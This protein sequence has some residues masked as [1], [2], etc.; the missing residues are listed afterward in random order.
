MVCG[1]L[2]YASITAEGNNGFQLGQDSQAGNL[3]SP[4]NQGDGIQLERRSL[5]NSLQEAIRDDRILNKDLVF[6]G[7]EAEEYAELFAADSNLY[8]LT[9]EIKG[10][11]NGLNVRVFAKIEGSISLD[12]DYEIDGSEEFIFLLVNDTKSNRETVIRVDEKSTDAI[13]A[14][15]AG[16]VGGVGKTETSGGGGASGGSGTSGGGAADTGTAEAGTDAAEE[17]TAESGA[18]DQDSSAES[19]DPAE[20]EDASDGHS[21][22][23]ADDTDKTGSDN[24][25]ENT[26]SADNGNEADKDASQTEIDDSDVPG[27]ETPDSP[28]DDNDASDQD[29]ADSGQ[30]DSD[31]SGDTDDGA[32]DNS[33]N[34]DSIES[35]A[36]ISRH[37][38]YRV[39]AVASSSDSEGK[40]TSS[41]A[42]PEKWIDGMIYQTVLLKGD[43]VTAFV[44]TAEDLGLDDEF[45]ETATGSNAAYFYEVDLDNANIQV[46]ADEGVL[47]ENAELRA[48]ELAEDGDDTDK[49]QEAKDALDEEG[50]EYDGMLAYDISFWDVEG[51][52]I[53][54][55]GDVRV[56][57][58]MN[59]DVLPEEVDPQSL[60]VQHHAETDRGI[61]VEP[62]ADA[63]DVTAGIVEVSDSEAVVEFT[64]DSFS[65]FTIT[66]TNNNETSTYFEVTVAYVDEGGVPI[67]VPSVDMP[68]PVIWDTENN[69]VE[70]TYDVS[71]NSEYNVSI[72]GYEYV[73]AKYGTRDIASFKFSKGRYNFSSRTLTFYNSSGTSVGTANTQ[74]VTVNL[75]YKA[76]NVVEDTIA[77]NGLLTLNYEETLG[78]T[79]IWERSLD[80]L[81]WEEVEIKKV[82]GESYNIENGGKSVNVVLDN[83]GRDDKGTQKYYRV[84]VINSDGTV[85]FTTAGYQ[86]PYYGELRNGSFESPKVTSGFNIHSKNGTDG[87]VW[88]T[89][90]DDECIEIANITKSGTKNAYFANRYDPTAPD[91]YQFAELNAEGPGAL[92]QDV[93]T[94]P[95]AKLY[96]ELHHRGRTATT[97][98]V[99]D[100]MYVVVMKAE[101]AASI[102]TQTQLER[103]V[104]QLENGNGPLGAEIWKIEAVSNTQWTRHTEEYR[105]SEGQYLTRFF[106]VSGE[107]AHGGKTIG[108]L[109][110]KVSF[111]ETVPDPAP[112]KGNLTVTKTVV[113]L[114]EEEAAG[115]KVEVNVKKNGSVVKKLTLTGF[116]STNGYQAQDS[117]QDLE[118]GYYTIEE[119]VL[120]GEQW[121]SRYNSTKI[122]GANVTWSENSPTSAVVNIVE[123]GTTSANITNTYDPAD[124][125]LTVKK[126]VG[127]NMGDKKKEFDFS[128]SIDGN[129]PI[130]FKLSHGAELGIDVPYG[131]T[132]VV[133]EIDSSGYTVTAAVDDQAATLEDASYTFE[134]VKKDSTITFTNTKEITSPTGIATE[135]MPY[136]LML[137]GAALCITCLAFF[138]LK[139]KKYKYRDWK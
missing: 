42:D 114:T 74:K 22:E 91:G 55:D 96:W 133:K 130:T 44:T 94:T 129:A 101:D 128:Y 87:L 11:R 93:L 45:L 51:N 13:L 9:P 12:E 72:P 118:P 33:S 14:A 125:K 80:N 27:S 106:F 77:S 24:A 60:L 50:V 117:V 69:N 76:K 99:N 90:A 137:F 78:D 103:L 119:T 10:D 61:K 68:G 29:T 84:K 123:N 81:A 97:R 36:S 134:A 105:V 136:I 83:V 139:K 67:K 107:T 4:S 6:E 89:T 17:S 79:Y 25:D 121:E 135:R 73:G 46:W 53:E 62:V 59:A 124:M 1:S 26:D 82:T 8:E 86:V 108:N 5:Y 64:V 38:T 58:T 127:G 104:T 75:Y 98:G 57:I 15:H 126:L 66:W 18:T 40:H 65:T 111:S 21:E 37:K 113:G 100:T 70:K 132:I 19:V 43:A 92:Y 115:Y 3:A 122:E 116:N 49:F 71:I 2:G 41:N 16:T 63:V 120:S 138:G 56:L 110:D 39:M 102:T 47:P 31:T 54:P 30:D 52:E 88:K 85:A 32:E 35:V 23:A 109:L 34:D 20:T 7:E 48:A 95:G 112:D 131:S 28:A